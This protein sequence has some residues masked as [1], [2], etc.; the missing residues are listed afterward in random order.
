MKDVSTQFIDRMAVEVQ[1]EGDAVLCL[2]G[3]GGTSNTFTPVLGAL[4]PYKLVR[5]DLPGSGRSHRVEGAL[6]IQRFVDATFNVAARLHIERFHLLGHSMGAI[7]ALHCAAQQPA[8]IKSLALFGPLLA[9]P[10]QAR[11]GIRARAA[12]ARS[13]GVPGMAEIADAIVA[14]ATSPDTRT[15]LP[16]AV[17]AVRESLM[18]Q[19]PEGYARCCEALADAQAA[20]L[21][22]ITAPT[23][24]VTGEDDA[25]APPQAVRA[26]HECLV[27]S[28]LVVLPRC[29]HWTTFERPDECERELK[30][31]LSARRH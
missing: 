17:A 18:R 27:G 7:V 5:I 6:S 28:R 4:S 3:L 24:L 10:A 14:G 22:N 9:P 25:V 19:D 11:E 29:G 13:E 1:G 16:L 23:L 8:R 12:K 26:L 30:S 2:H 20:A 31:F 21:E 15:R